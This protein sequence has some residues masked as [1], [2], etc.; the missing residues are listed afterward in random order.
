MREHHS[1]SE[2]DKLTQLIPDTVLIK[3]YVPFRIELRR[4]VEVQISVHKMSFVHRIIPAT[5]FHFLRL[6]DKARKKVS[7]PEQ[8]AVLWDEVVP[9]TLSYLCHKAT[10]MHKT[11][12]PIDQIP[13]AASPVAEKEGLPPLVQAEHV[14]EQHVKV[15]VK[16]QPPGLSLL[17]CVNCMLR[18]QHHM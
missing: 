15:P 4:Y 8:E 7:T 17:C 9:E 16:L 10:P 5:L 2:W 6:L 14:Q 13:Q 12:T 1:I 18:M 3:N 11:E